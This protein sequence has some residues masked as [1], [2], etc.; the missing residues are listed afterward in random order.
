MT[1]VRESIAAWRQTK[2]PRLAAVADLATARALDAQPRPALATGTK[3][4]DV[5]AWQAAFQ[6][7]DELDLPRLL[8]AVGTARSPIS[9][10][11]VRLLATA[12]DPRVVTGL[13]R[14]LEAP[15]FRAGTALPFFR[16]CATALAEAGD[17]RVRPALEDLG[18][19]YKGI[20]ETSIGDLVATLL[21]RTAASLDQVKPGPLP[22][23]LD[24]QCSAWEALFEAERAAGQR[25]A[26]QVRSTR[27]SDE[28]L[29]AAIYAA[30]DDDAPRHV[31]ADALLE[32]GDERG[33]FISLQLARAR[34]EATPAQRLRES[35]LAH[36]PKR[37]S[38]WALPLSAGGEV[39]FGRGFPEFLA[40]N[41]K[42]AKRVVG[43]A[44]LRTLARVAGFEQ[45]S[46][47]VAAELLGSPHL[48][49]ATH[50]G[51]LSGALLDK[52]E[53]DLPWP[54]ISLV[55]APGPGLLSRF[56]G[57][58]ALELCSPPSRGLDGGGVLDSLTLLASGGLDAELLASVPGLTTLE[59]RAWQKDWA[60][61]PPLARLGRLERLA[62]QNAPPPAQLEG[63]TA[64]HFECRWTRELQLDG[65]LAALGRLRSFAFDN[66]TVPTDLCGVALAAARARGFERLGLGLL[67]LERPFTA[68]GVGELRLPLANRELVPAFLGALPPDAVTRL[69]LRPPRGAPAARLAA[70]PEA[71]VLESLRKA[72]PLPLEL[73]WY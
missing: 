32:R 70:P 13:L 22:A 53:G 3:Q 33:E 17:P 14:L 41:P 18:A 65:V 72:T 69:V 52:L 56:P 34:G 46:V 29:L 1:V 67:S 48:R 62:V 63:C 40:L 2:H 8:A 26:S 36:D 61:A 66:D 68:T 30:P 73:A 51:R 16:A 5:A 55:E 39:V 45:C 25:A 38:A 24:R 11:R 15:P 21:L 7:R 19:R 58:R 57:L 31:F 4:V 6:G 27:A 20:I 54:S 35:Q 50:V 47:K 42:Q 9:T 12:N 37:L 60:A 28:E 49:G 44:A 23:A 10:E 64:T 43:H 71:D 59:V